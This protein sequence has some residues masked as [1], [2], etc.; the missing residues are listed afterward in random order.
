VL[1]VAWAGGYALPLLLAGPPGVVRLAEWGANLSP[2]PGPEAGWRLLASTFLHATPWHLLSNLLALG[3]L[4]PSA[5]RLLGRSGFWVVFV[6]GGLAASLAS[7]AW[8]SAVVERASSSVGASGALFAVGGAMLAAAWRVRAALPP[9]R[10]RALGGALLVLLGQGLVAGLTREAT[11]NAA[12]A[13]GALAGVLLG[14]AL[15][16]SP[17]RGRRAAR[18]LALAATLCVAL[19]FASLVL[20]L[21]H[22]VHAA[23]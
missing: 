23:G 4:G 5:A 10:A 1:A 22:G 7:L 18:A 8:R 9:G 2:W 11:D 16:P 14:I 3:I 15:P 17:A 20:A 6:T 13:G 12:H 21:A 19:L